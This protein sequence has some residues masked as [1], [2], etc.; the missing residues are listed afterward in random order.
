MK[1]RIW[2]GDGNGK[3]YNGTLTIDFNPQGGSVTP[4][5]TTATYG[6]TYGV[7]PTPEHSKVFNGWFTEATGGMQITEGMNVML[8]GSPQTLY[9]QWGDDKYTVTDDVTDGS[10]NVSWA[11]YHQPLLI[12]S[13][14]QTKV[15]PCRHP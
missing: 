10:I 5:S 15:T 14:P 4:T 7:L 12:S 11:E 9:A 1:N 8:V 3:L 2:Y 6:S 13:S